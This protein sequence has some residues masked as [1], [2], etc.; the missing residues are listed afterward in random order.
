MTQDRLTAILTR[1]AGRNTVV[2]NSL[3]RRGWSVL[4]CPAIDIREVLVDAKEVPRPHQFDLVVFVS[5]AAVT[6][7]HAQLTA[8]DC[9]DWPTHSL[10]ACMGPVTANTIR[11]VF[12]QSVCILHPDAALAQDS[13]SLWPILLDLAPPLK[14]VLIVRGQDGRDW[15]SQRLRE[16]GVEVSFQ[17]AYRRQEAQW[18]LT[19]SE[20]FRSLCHQGVYP[21]W[22]L[23]S[24][25][26]VEAIYRSI[27][28][29]GLLDW[30]A[31]S[32]FILTH[33]RLRPLLSQLLERPV[34][35]LSCML[36]SPEDIVILE[37][38]EQISRKDNFF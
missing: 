35:R 34:E 5:R 23:T 16:R 33:E 2:M 32:A 25:H 13:E 38:F 29:I 17:Q 20:H 3:L 22:L 24:P 28:S 30:F 26:G 21:T 19:I 18:P 1:P 14:K 37:C 7:Y 10:A 36:A 12:G 15:L 9:S 8:A 6:G 4:E 27:K 31:A 11:R